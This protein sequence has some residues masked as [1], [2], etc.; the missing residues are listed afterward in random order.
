MIQHS[1]SI[2]QSGDLNYDERLFKMGKKVSNPGMIA[3]IFL[4]LRNICLAICG[5]VI[6]VILVT[7]STIDSRPH[8]DKTVLIRMS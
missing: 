7:N 3:A 1:R 2:L 4:L 6:P 5:I 8:N